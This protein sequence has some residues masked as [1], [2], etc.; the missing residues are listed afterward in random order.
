M[1]FS[2][3]TTTATALLIG[4]AAAA[5]LPQAN[6]NNCANNNA[7]AN[8]NQNAGTTIADLQNTF[9]RNNPN[10]TPTDPGNPDDLNG[11]GVI[12]VFEAGAQA[13]KRQNGNGNRRAC[14]G[15][16]ANAN[17]NANA[18]ANANGNAN[19]NGNAA[20]TNANSGG[21]TIADLQ[22]TFNRNNPNG[23]PTNPGNPDDLNGDGVINVFEAGAQ[24]GKN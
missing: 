5:P 11:D 9:D 6:N 8:A 16:K 14:G 17:V 15:A 13:S 10:G 1:K 4:L 3:L 21:T 24:A 18:N 12:N 19:G 7:N 2:L 22:N 20:A 23:T